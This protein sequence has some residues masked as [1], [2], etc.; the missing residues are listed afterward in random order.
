VFGQVERAVVLVHD[1][2]RPSGKGTAE[3]SGKPTARKALDRCSEG[4][5]LLTTLPWPV[6]V[7]PMDSWM[8]K[9]DFQGSW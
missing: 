5:F 9:R 8:M 3:F 6:T 1:R 4:S 2:G 7:E